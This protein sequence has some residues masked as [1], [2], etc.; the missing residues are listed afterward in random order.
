MLFISVVGAGKR[1]HGRRTW[2]AE[3]SLPGRPMATAGVVVGRRAEHSSSSDPFG[4]EGEGRHGLGGFRR[5][6]AS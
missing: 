6:S 5:F 3:K 2:A 4:D 1:M